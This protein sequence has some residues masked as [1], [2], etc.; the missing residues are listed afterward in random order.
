MQV[1]VEWKEMGTA[2][3][4]RSS[5]LVGKLNDYF[6]IT[7]D[8]RSEDKY[9]PANCLTQMFTSK[10]VNGEM[11]KRRGIQLSREGRKVE[12]FRRERVLI[13]HGIT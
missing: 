5:L 11:K 2:V 4:C 9:Y 8:W 13:L 6:V 1:V 7:G 3:E 10:Q 12:N